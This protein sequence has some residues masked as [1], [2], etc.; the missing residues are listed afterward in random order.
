MP[1]RDEHDAIYGEIK[2]YLVDHE[3]VCNRAD[4]IFGSVP[5]IGKVL[6]EIVRSHFIIADLT[7]Q[8]AN[9]FYELGIAHSFKDSHHIILIAQNE[10][11]IPF[12]IKHLNTIVYSPENIKYLTSQIL[13]SILDNRHQFEFFE[14]LQKNSIIGVINDERKGFV[15]VFINAMDSSL[16]V[17]TAIL[18]GEYADFTNEQIKHVLDATRGLIYSCA[19]DRNF[20][21]LQGLVHIFSELLC[22]SSGFEYS[23]EL[24]KNFLY[25]CKLE[26]YSLSHTEIKALQSQLAVNLAT[27]RVFQHVSL[28]W[29]IEYF[30][31]SKSSTIDL[32][33]YWVER[34]LLTSTDPAV[35]EAIVNAVL[36]EN[37]YIREH[38]ADLVGEKFLKEGRDV[39]IA[40]LGREKNIFTTASIITALGK[41]SDQTCYPPIVAWFERNRDDVIQTRNFFVLKRIGIALRN[42]GINDDFSNKFEIDYAEHLVPSA[43]F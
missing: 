34:F 35:N 2:K 23:L 39:L 37:H 31:K 11:D 27:K 25:E 13:K 26:N 30:S 14:A 20:S 3:Y 21:T 32:N 40:Q 5:I 24:T 36:H 1:F 43:V 22:G 15:D 7:G 9:V 41:L 33:R 29:I 19:P 18:N 17:V 10:S 38:M 12:D 28:V 6:K 4:E 8:N 42:I 16:F